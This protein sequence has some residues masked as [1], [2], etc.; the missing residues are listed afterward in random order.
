M[1]HLLTVAL[2]AFFIWTVLRYLL[3]VIVPERLAI[4]A[5]GAVTYG[6]WQIPRPD[7]TGILAASGLALLLVVAYSLLGS[8]PAPPSWRMPRLRLRGWSRH[9]AATGTGV[10]P[11]GPGHR[12]PE[13]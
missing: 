12:I 6:T 7:V 4:V 3:P 9:A 10:R 11:G 2:A 5:L 1:L 8:V 13:L